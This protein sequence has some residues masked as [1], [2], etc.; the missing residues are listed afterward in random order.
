MIYSSPVNANANSMIWGS[1]GTGSIGVLNW[2]Q[3]VEP[4]KFSS[5]HIATRFSCA[6]HYDRE[7]DEL[8]FSAPHRP[9]LVVPGNPE[10]N[11]TE[12]Y[13]QATEWVKQEYEQIR[14]PDGNF[15]LVKK[16]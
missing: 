6:R 12:F 1:V 7:R 14:L 9:T 16:A 10:P 11:P 15:M 2:D 4:Q 13:K 8:T 5:L 3:R